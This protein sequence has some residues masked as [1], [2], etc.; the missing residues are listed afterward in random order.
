MNRRFIWRSCRTLAY[1]AVG[2]LVALIAS[3]FGLWRTWSAKRVVP[4]L[5][6]PN[7]LLALADVQ[8][9]KDDAP[10]QEIADIEQLRRIEARCIELIPKVRAAVVGIIS[11]SNRR[12]SGVILTPDGL[13]LS[14]L[15]VTHMRAGFSDGNALHAPGEQATII[16]ES[17]VRYK[18]RL[19][20]ANRIY[21]LSLLQLSG[22]GP[23][24]FVPLQSGARVHK[25]DWVVK[26]GHPMG[27]RKGRAALARLG[28]VLGSTTEAFVADCRIASGDSG[29]PYFNLDGRLVGMINDADGDISQHYSEGLCG[30][31]F[32]MA[33]APAQISSLLQPMKEGQITPSG[34]REFAVGLERIRPLAAEL[35]TEG[36]AQKRALQSLGTMFRAR[37]VEVVNGAVPVGLATV[38]DDDGYAVTK[39]T[40]L[41]PKPQCRMP[42]GSVVSINLIGVDK[43][44]DLA[45]LRLPMR[46]VHPVSWTSR[47]EPVRAGTVSAALG[48]SGSVL[49][50][51]IVSVDTQALTN[52]D[53]PTYDLPLRVK[54]AAPEVAGHV[55]EIDGHYVLDSVDGLAETAGL[56]RGDRLVSVEGHEIGTENDLSASVSKRF[57]GDTVDVVFIREARTMIIQLPLAADPGIWKGTFRSDDFPVAFEYSPPVRNNQCGG[58]LVDLKG[59]VIGVTVGN[60]APHAGWAIPIET[61]H[62]LL[63]DARAGTLSPWNPH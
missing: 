13:V 32:Y 57:S 23:Y 49:S 58:P 63:V 38:L 1:L 29:G 14:Q 3:R 59:Q 54:A 16:L 8:S 28:R 7:P 55:S 33:I 44:L 48:V 21:D 19:L 43:A 11:P 27:P 6:E 50:W 51:G 26:L 2:V 42:D 46:N 36:N 39:A 15:H 62:Q 4:E 45:I 60:L 22:P 18:A 34:R 52:I 35:R 37:I 20:G 40:V 31:V 47:A 24:P 9:T 61:V 25:G 56:S 30:D 10:V 53:R 12:A 17:G 5:A 41:P